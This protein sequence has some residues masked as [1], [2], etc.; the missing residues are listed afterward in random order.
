MTHV[1]FEQLFTA[2]LPR[3]PL[4]SLHTTWKNP[5]NDGMALE[6]CNIM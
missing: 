2:R 1:I 3:I 5:E 4:D 6:V